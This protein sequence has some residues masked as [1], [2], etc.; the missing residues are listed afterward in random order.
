MVAIMD[1]KIKDLTDKSASMLDFLVRHKMITASDSPTIIY[2]NYIK[3]E[4]TKK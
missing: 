4:S 2:I 1:K 3:H